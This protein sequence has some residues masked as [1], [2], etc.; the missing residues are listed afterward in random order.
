MTTTL[1]PLCL[2]CTRFVEFRR[3]TVFDAIPDAIWENRSDH[4]Q[5]FKGDNGDRFIPAETWNPVFDPF[6]S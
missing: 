2:D 1:S 3:C 4:R 5:P 6:P